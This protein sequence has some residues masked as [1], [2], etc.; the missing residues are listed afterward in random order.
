MKKFLLPIMALWLTLSFQSTNAQ[1]INFPRPSPTAVVKQNFAT[2]FIEI[3]YSRPSV[4][5]RKIFGEIVA[6]GEIWRTGANAAT[7]IEFGQDIIIQNTTVP[8]GKYGLLTIP[9]QNEWTIIITKDLNV[10]GPRAYNKDNDMVRVTSKVKTST[11]IT[12]TFTIDI[13]GISDNQCIISLSWENT[14]VHMQVNA[15]YGA[16]LKSQIEE[17]MS[18]DS[19]PY[20]AAASYYYAQNMDLEKA[21][22]WI[23]I[24]NNLNPN[25][26]WVQSLKA[27]IEFATKKFQDALNTAQAA[28]ESAEKAGNKN[29][30]KEM[31][32]LIAN[33]QAHPDFKPAKKKK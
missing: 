20:Y 31:N 22:E 23:A 12:E 2:S 5:G 11:D 14:T 27:N 9:G 26:Y 4:K 6:Y 15:N 29:V 30:V 13:G 1:S 7:T 16:Q 8:K 28:A 18:K 17:A 21:L 10:T 32:D 24:E 3:N 33:I 25:R 19:R